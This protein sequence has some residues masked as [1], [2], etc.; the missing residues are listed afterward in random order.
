MTRLWWVRHGPT[1]AKGMTGWTDL[2]ADLTD[3]ARLARLAAALPEAPVISSDLWRA[4]AT[5]DAVAGDRPRLP[6]DPD[7]REINFGDWEKRRPD[8]FTGEE[9]RAL[10]AFYDRPGPVRAPGGESW[11]ALTAR[12]N[13]AVDR[14]LATGARD[15]IVVA[16][17]GPVLS[18]VQ[19]ALGLSAYDAFARKVDTLS[20]T[21]IAY[22][23]GCRLERLN[24]RP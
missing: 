2:P 24:H 11:D 23:P 10:R 19:R 3:T 13:R 7:L 14:L 20:V 8:G 4:V 15:V 18:Q 22:G 12:V 17:M 16:H 5:A 1:H 9:A 6:H 21:R